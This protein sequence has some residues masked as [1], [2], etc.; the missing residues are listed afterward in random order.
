MF[1]E[2]CG[3]LVTVETRIMPSRETMRMWAQQVAKAQGFT[4]KVLLQEGLYYDEN[5][6]RNGVWAGV[7]NN[8]P[9]VLKVYDETVRLTDEPRALAAF[10]Q[11]NTNPHLKAPALYASEMLTSKKGW[12]IMEHLPPEGSFFTSPLSRADRQTF[13]TVF[14]NYRLNFPIQPSRTLTLGE[15]LP[16][17]EFHCL[18]I[19]RWFELATNKEEQRKLEG[20]KTVID[21]QTFIPLYV[22]ALT[23]LRREF[24]HRAMIWSHGHFKPKD[25]YHLPNSSPCYLTDFAHTRLLPEGYEMA[26]VIWAD[27]MMAADWRLDY[28]AWKGGIDAWIALFKPVASELS[29]I[30]YEA[31]MTA[32]LIERTLGSLLADV[33]A[34]NRPRPE[35][36]ARTAHLMHLLQDLLQS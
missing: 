30:D 27:W 6:V 5:N 18:R 28:A 26:L 2:Q 17:D 8:K 19:G 4:L 21:Q 1:F 36:E 25:L 7:Y 15:S 29:I 23:A 12:L 13:V 11:S 9:A 22:K 14:A 34:T 16:P 32:S 33:A 3:K 24:S 10:H 35:Q 31:L 20:E